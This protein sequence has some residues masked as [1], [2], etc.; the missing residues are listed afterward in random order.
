M[1]AFST[2][3]LQDILNI[4]NNPKD[5]IFM[6]IVTENVAINVTYTTTSE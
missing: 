4:F 2:V 3:S 1:P 5:D 6:Y